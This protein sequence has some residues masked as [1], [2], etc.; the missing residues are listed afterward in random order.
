MNRRECLL[1]AASAL[2]LAATRRVWAQPEDPELLGLAEYAPEIRYGVMIP[3][4]DGVK[5][6]ATLYLPRG[7]SGPLPT[8]FSHTPY[9]ADLYH[10]EG[11]YFSTNGFPYL[12]VDMRGRGDSE[13]EFS[14]FGTEPEDGHDIVEWIA[15]QPFCDGKVATNGH[16]F[17]G[18]TQ[19]AAVRGEAKLATMVPL[20]PAWAGTDFPMNGNIFYAQPVPWLTHVG[21]RTQRDALM[22]DGLYHVS[23]QIDF[24]RSG[25]PFRELDAFYGMPFAKFQEW[26]DHPFQSDYW[27]RRN[28]A[29]AQLSRLTIP[30]LTLCGYFD[31]DQPGALEAYRQHLRHA[32]DKAEHYLVIGPWGHDQVRKPSDTYQGIALGQ[33]SVIDT[34]KLHLDWYS[35]TMSG[36]AKPEFLQKKIAYYVLGADRWRYADRLEDV[37]AHYETLRLTSSGNPTSVYRAGGLVIGAQVE[38]DGGPDHYVY[39][40]RDLNGLMRV[41]ALGGPPLLDQTAAQDETAPQLI[42]QTPA[43]ASDVELSGVFKL[44]AWIS[45]DQPD[46]D[47]HASIHVIGRDGSSVFLTEQRLRAR[48]REGL[49]GEKLVDTEEPLPYE[50]KNFS[51]VSRLIRQGS[52][53]R[54]ILRPNDSFAYQRN[55][56]SGKPVADETAAD[57][58][59]VTVRL[60]HDAAHP[61]ALSIPIGQLES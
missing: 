18:Y 4:R 47:F 13:G 6:A 38:E 24:L 9:T 40:P 3:M 15:R 27:D 5:L 12:A 45:L 54:L 42:Y 2:G 33:A 32:G 50:F 51:F 16:S 11:M 39:D 17:V 46:T 53:L 61:S 48:H 1:S 34:L 26:M 7:A 22:K 60:H 43:F 14:P 49:R 30:V 59:P 37:T 57:A 41:L 35:W 21:G 36:G 52:R 8:I 25:R 20:S 56:N 44:T 58:R 23:K 55:R 10:P 19:W 28:P 31:G 29:P